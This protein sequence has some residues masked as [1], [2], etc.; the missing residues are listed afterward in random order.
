VGGDAGG[1]G[2]GGW[3]TGA[4]AP[5]KLVTHGLGSRRGARQM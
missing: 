5:T 1:E 2:L 4:M 3:P